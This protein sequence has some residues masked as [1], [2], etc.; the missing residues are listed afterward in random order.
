VNGRIARTRGRDGRVQ[1][2]RRR[3]LPIDVG[4]SIKAS[5]GVE[6][7]V[8][9]NDAKAMVSLVIRRRATGK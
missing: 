9:L 4:N 7:D 2:K 6:L 5:S 1:A 3:L 8:S